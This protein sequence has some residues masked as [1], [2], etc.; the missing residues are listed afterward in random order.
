MTISKHSKMRKKTSQTKNTL[1]LQWWIR[2]N[3]ICYKGPKLNCRKPTV[4]FTSRW[5]RRN[6]WNSMIHLYPWQS[7]ATFQRSKTSTF[8][9]SHSRATTSTTACL[10]SSSSWQCLHACSDRWLTKRMKNRR[11][12]LQ[13]NTLSCLSNCP[14]QL[15][16]ICAF[17]PRWWQGWRSW[18]MQTTRRIN[19]ATMEL[20]CHT[21]LVTSNSWQPC[22]V[23]PSMFSS[24][25]TNKR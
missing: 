13:V 24:W 4:N 16:F 8:W 9:V 20:K 3:K 7:F 2:W 18:N 23:K 5:L 21:S 12:C 14:V 6:M 25:P 17:T 11:L 15:R 1:H 19:S 10:S 22:T